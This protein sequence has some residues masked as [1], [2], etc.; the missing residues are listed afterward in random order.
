MRTKVKLKIALV[1]LLCI[2]CFSVAAWAVRFRTTEFS[3]E[4]WAKGPGWGRWR[5]R[6]DVCD[7]ITTEW[8]TKDRITENLGR[9]TFSGDGGDLPGFYLI[10]PSG[11]T[12]FFESMYIYIKFDGT[13]QAV[14][15][16]VLPM[17]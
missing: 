13:R 6:E 3:K 16:T 17:S 7:K 14:R 4:V 1:V 9:R 11:W 2:A 8:F 10:L 15:A 12:S 5:M